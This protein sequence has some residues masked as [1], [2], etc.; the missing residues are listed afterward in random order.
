MLWSVL[1][2]ALVTVL[3]LESVR[4][5]VSDT[6]FVIDQSRRT[7]LLLVMAGAFASP[8]L[9]P[10][11]GRLSGGRAL[12]VAAVLLG[13]ARVGLQFVPWP[14]ARVVLAGL[15]LAAAGWL[16]V[17]LLRWRARAGLGLVLGAVLDLAIRTAR[18]TLDLPWMPG[19]GSHLVTGFLVL[20]LM[21]SLFLVVS[22]RGPQEPRG[23][24]GFL[25]LGPAFGLLHLVVTNLGFASV[26]TGWSLV[27]ASTVLFAGA[28]LAVLLLPLVV[29]HW[30]GWVAT[31]LA[32]GLGFWLAGGSGWS[33]ALGVVLAGA[34]W[35]VL[36]T[37]CGIGGRVLRRPA[38]SGRVALALAAGQLI[39]VALLFRY[40]TQTGD[41]IVVFGLLGILALLA[42]LD[43]PRAWPAG[44]LA[45]V[46][47]VALGMA[48]PFAGAIVWQALQSHER[49]PAALPRNELIVVTYNI[50]SGYDGRDRWNLE[51]TAR[52]IESAQADVVLLQEVSRGWLVTSS[53]DQLVW[54][55]RRLG[56]HA[57]WGP[58]SEDGLWGNAVLTRS[59]PLE[60]RTVRFGRTQNLRRGAV[61]V[62]LATP[63]GSLCVASTHLDDPR[64]ATEVRLAQIEELLAFLEACRPLVLGGD[65]NADP[66][67]P[68]IAALRER[69]LIDAAATIGATAST[70][71]DQRRIDYVFVS[72]GIE[73]L[74]GRVP[75]A[76]A[77]DHRPVLVRLVVR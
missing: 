70:S 60:T 5:F 46:P 56:M 47:H 14:I 39:Q 65:F 30:S 23:A 55:A 12:V 6:V 22:D 43:W 1:A 25:A 41:R 17:P 21:V 3:G 58:A 53:A 59:R 42:A 4:V 71:A 19:L 67:S 11:V 8:V 50:Q 37:T 28:L 75:T 57:S 15:G 31:A 35:T 7:L 52:V 44:T 33:A 76:T 38:G 34:S 10:I 27:R 68:E 16:L 45:L 77:S 74:A 20:A 24:L 61:A 62:R 36:V 54:L 51:A 69:G 2:V 73:I 18:D 13:L 40:Y 49:P 63:T 48:L 9:V 29:R 32:G 66:E 72:E 26:H 64:P